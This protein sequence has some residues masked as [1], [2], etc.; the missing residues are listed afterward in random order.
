MVGWCIGRRGKLANAAPFGCSAYPTS[1]SKADRRGFLRSGPVDWLLRLCRAIRID[2]WRS[3]PPRLCHSGLSLRW[4]DS[5]ADRLGRC[6]PSRPLSVRPNLHPFDYSRR[7]S[8]FLRPNS[9]PWLECAIHSCRHIRWINVRPSISLVAAKEQCLG[10]S[11]GFCQPASFCPATDSA[12][13][14][15]HNFRLR[16]G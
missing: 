4:P 12:L 10:K 5:S 7:G 6:V 2:R 1:S 11:F 16:S 13:H 8:G 15:R 9:R 3:R 14:L